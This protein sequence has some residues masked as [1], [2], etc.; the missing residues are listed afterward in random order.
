MQS[1]HAYACMLYVFLLI[2]CYVDHT[3]HVM[4]VDL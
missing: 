4:Y 2:Y 3:V 1:M